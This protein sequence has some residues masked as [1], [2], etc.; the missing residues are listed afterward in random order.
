[1]HTQQP[2]K[3]VK[4][5]HTPGPW[6]VENGTNVIVPVNV[7]GEDVACLVASVADGQLYN[8]PQTAY[9]NAKLIAAAPDLLEAATR[10]FYALEGTEQSLLRGILSAAIAK[11]TE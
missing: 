6:E 8:C 1:M 3:T 5:Q 9:A 10:V 2:V 11:A 7:A 4:T